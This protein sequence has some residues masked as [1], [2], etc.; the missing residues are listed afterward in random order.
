MKEQQQGIALQIMEAI[1]PSVDLDRVLYRLVEVV[2]EVTSCDRAAIFLVHDD[3]LR[4]KAVAAR[5]ANLELF[6]RFR[7]MEPISLGDVP[8]RRRLLGAAEVV[9]IEDTSADPTV[10]KQWVEEFDTASLAAAP[11][12]VDGEVLGIL[13]V[14]YVRPHVFTAVEVDVIRSIALGTR[15]AL[16]NAALHERLARTAEVRA[17][18]LAGMAAVGSAV[19]LHD[20]LRSITEFVSSLFEGRTVSISLLGAHGRE[21]SFVGE[22]GTETRTVFPLRTSSATSGYLSIGGEPPPPAHELD[23][24]EAFASQAALAIERS[25]LML[26]LR[27]RLRRTEALYRMSDL[28]AGVANVSTVLRRLNEEV[29]ADAGFECVDVGFHNA[30]LADLLR[31]RTLG[32][33]DVPLLAQLETAGVLARVA[34]PDGTEATAVRVAGRVAGLLFVRPRHDEPVGES[35]DDLLH[36]IAAGIGQLAHRLR[37]RETLRETRSRLEVGGAR[38]TIAEEFRST[39]GDVLT[40]VWRSLSSGVERAGEDAATRDLLLGLRADVGRALMDLQSAQ[41]ALAVLRGRDRALE[42]GIRDLLESFSEVSELSTN[43]RVVGERRDVADPVKE[44]LCAVVFEALSTVAAASR[45]SAVIVTIAY[46]D[47]LSLSFRD[48]GVGLSQRAGV[49]PRAGVHYGL[50]V[51]GD[52]VA[53]L[54]GRVSVEPAEPRGTRLTVRIPAEALAQVV[55]AS[56]AASG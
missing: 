31:C 4:P 9:V 51:I 34:G 38:H 37:L 12:V 20:V 29:C 7:R 21:Q 33:E 27:Q 23:L 39:A 32:R 18:L 56:S 48:D 47:G 11:L 2:L 5:R 25:R 49:G 10:P 50:R 6:R 36:A 22:R 53:T 44:V 13:V 16:G 26:D 8:E 17:K 52:R 35:D 43:L 54:G 19:E 55:T 24:V 14:D 40:G 3:E 1:N 41:E 30:K 15:V 28:L 46:G 45:A 42:D